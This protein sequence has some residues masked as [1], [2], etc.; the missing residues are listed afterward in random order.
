M[1]MP[2]APKPTSIIAQVVGPG[3]LGARLT[4]ETTPESRE[5]LPVEVNS[6]PIQ[7]LYPCHPRGHWKD[8]AG[9][10]NP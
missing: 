5:V 9:P 4:L 7:S 8:Q 3:T 6:P 2:T 1:D 10:E